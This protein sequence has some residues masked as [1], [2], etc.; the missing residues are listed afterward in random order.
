[1]R[2]VH[3]PRTL[4]QLWACLDA[5]PG[6]VLFAGGTDLF[7]KMR[8]HKLDAPALIGLE[9]IEELEGVR[10]ENDEIRMGACTTHGALLR[11][12]AIEA[13]LPVLARA[14]S[15]LGSPPIRAMGTLG[16]NICTASPAGDSLPPLYVLRAQ[17][18]LASSE[19]NRSMPIGDFIVGPGRTRL[20]PGEILSAVRVKKPEGFNV[21]HFEKV[22][23]RKSMACAVTSLAAML[24][25]S[26]SGI[27]EECR[28]AWGSVGP[29]VMTDTAIERFLAGKPLSHETLTAAA[30]R[31]R[32]CPSSGSG[33]EKAA[34]KPVC[35]PTLERG[36]EARAGGIGHCRCFGTAVPVSGVVSPVDDV[37]ASAGY[38]RTLSGNLLFRLIGLSG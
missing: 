7:V 23:R 26:P 29:T 20:R 14:L 32:L 25:L 2:P 18:E 24:R 12:P 6:A 21:H 11:H 15:T 34:G 13:H 9:R 19:G 27:L 28:L 5:D 33:N 30:N 1:M 22:G 38:R 36:D 10:E 8:A 3:L 37:R 31:V 4:P 16:G 17:V 35:I